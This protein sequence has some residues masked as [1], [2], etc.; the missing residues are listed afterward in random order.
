MQASRLGQ[1]ATTALNAANEIAVDAFLNEQIRFT[2]IYKV[3]QQVVD[4]QCQPALND[5]QAVLSHDK[6]CRDL[7]LD[8]ITRISQ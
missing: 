4:A 7:A 6:L 3:N 2:D 8:I 1:A 5:I